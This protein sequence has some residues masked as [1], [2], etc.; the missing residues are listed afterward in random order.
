MGEDTLRR[1]NKAHP[2]VAATVFYGPEDLRNLA[3]LPPPAT[4]DG[5]ASADVRSSHRPVVEV[6]L[7]DTISACARLAWSRGVRPCALNF[8][9]AKNPGRSVE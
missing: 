8:A 2:S 4:T 7:E 5:S 6:V 9:S 1:M 3:N